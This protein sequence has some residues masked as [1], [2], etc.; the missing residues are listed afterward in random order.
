MLP[1]PMSRRDFLSRLR[2]RLEPDEVELS[3]F[4]KV[5][6]YASPSYLGDS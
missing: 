2:Q 4:I 5:G 3:L 6:E 1:N